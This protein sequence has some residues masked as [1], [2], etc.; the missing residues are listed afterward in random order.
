RKFLRHPLIDLALERDDQ[1][2]QP[3]QALPAP[4]A[5]FRLVA[6]RVLDVDLTVVAGEAHREPFLRLSAISALPGFTHDLARNVVAEPV[7]DLGQLLDRADIGLLVKLA[8]RGRP[9]VLARIDA[10]LRQLPGMRGVDVLRPAHALADEHAA[11]A[12]EHD[13]ADAG[14]VGKGLDAG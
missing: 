2:R 3:L 10:A 7:R 14:P 8:Q 13:D 5:E 12:V 6:G 1:R 9:R 4:F 11:G